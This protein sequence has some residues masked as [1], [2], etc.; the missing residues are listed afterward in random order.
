MLKCLPQ[1]IGNIQ[2]LNTLDMSYNK[3]LYLPISML[4]LKELEY[5]D[6]TM[7]SFQT[8]EYELNK[9]YIEQN[10][11]RSNVQVQ[12]FVTLSAN[13]VLQYRFVASSNL[14][15]IYMYIYVY[16]ELL[17]LSVTPFMNK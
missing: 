5:L 1:S 7:N 13:I 4:L 10:N 8:Q 3:L 14:S 6:I 12:R 2:N 11:K 16:I 17:I 15:F 9:Q